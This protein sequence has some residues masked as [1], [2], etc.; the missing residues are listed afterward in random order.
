MK[1]MF[2]YDSG[3][4]S[5]GKKVPVMWDTKQ[6]VN[7]H[8]IVAGISGMG[9]TYTLK[10]IISHV[11]AT[12]AP[13][14]KMRVHVIDVHGDIDIPGASTVVFS[15]QSPYGLVNPL[16]VNPDPHFGGLRKQIQ[17]FIATMN[18]V[19]R[20][21]GNKQEACLR[22][23]LTDLYITHGFKQD[24]PSTWMIDP[25]SA[26]FL[27]D[28]SNRLYIDVPRAEKDQ[29]KALGARWEPTL[30]C[31]WVQPDKYQGGITRWPPKTLGRTQPSIRDALVLARRILSQSFLGADEEAITNLEIFQRASEQYQNSVLEAMRRGEKL[32]EDEALIATLDKKKHAAIDTFTQYVESIKTGREIETLMKYSSTDVL[33]SVVDRLENL[34]AMGMFKTEPAPH[35]ENV[36]VWRY[37]TNALLLDERRLAGLFKMEEIFLNAIQRGEQDDVVEIIIADEGHIYADDDPENIMNKIG[38]EARK[39]GLSLIV[40]TQS[41]KH[42][43]DGFMMSCGTKVILG[44]DE[45]E[46]R[47]SATKFRVTEQA[48]AWTKAREKMLVQTKQKGQSK[49]DWKWTAIADTIPEMEA[50]ALDA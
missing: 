6:V 42:V 27:S 36:M 10:K 32:V 23:L 28:G 37:V 9:K 14:Q 18:R 44:L 21:L 34:D 45:S 13:G 38:L 46:W 12:L 33:A 17:G 2:G 49:N 22:N 50:V 24:D 20:R 29:A 30:M 3:E 26:R 39:F 47:S 31:W 43:P 8:M 5:R 19:M 4:L 40:A 7:P 1:A 15:E 11:A 16:K 35:D 25:A 48:L 41:P